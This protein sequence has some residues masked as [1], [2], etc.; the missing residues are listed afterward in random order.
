MAKVVSMQGRLQV[1]DSVL[2]GYQVI[3]SLAAVKPRDGHKVSGVLVKKGFSYQIVAPSELSG[4][5]S[6]FD[7]HVFALDR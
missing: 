5:L 2:F 4:T 7:A 1:G 3:G 6:L